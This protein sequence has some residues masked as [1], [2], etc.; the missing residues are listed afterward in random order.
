MKGTFFAAA[1]AMAGAASAS[2]H[3]HAH[4]QF[5]KRGNAASTGF[6]QPTATDGICTPGCT[7]IWK[8]ITGEATRE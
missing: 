3:R 4:Q 8:T 5:A 6:P 1:A 2:N 7:T